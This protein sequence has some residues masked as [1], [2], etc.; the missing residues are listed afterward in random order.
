[1]SSPQDPYPSNQPP[2][3]QQPYG[4]PAQGQQLG[5]GQSYP[6]PP[7]FEKQQP[8][9]G[10][11]PYGSQQQPG[12]G[13]YGQ[14]GYGQAGYGAPPNPYGNQ[15]LNSVQ[16]PTGWFIV[17]WL[18]LWPLAIYSL[19][20][21]WQNI[22]RALFAGDVRGAQFQADRVKKFGI[23]A[24]CVGIGWITLWIIIAVAVGSSVNNCYGSYC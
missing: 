6:P 17:N 22:D 23:I 11:Q 21:A 8:Y 24:L 19:T 7:S 15:Y 9:G 1:M 14:G 4:Q 12:Q 3:G 20:S 13:G 18:F 16:K 2:Q 10:Q 5:A